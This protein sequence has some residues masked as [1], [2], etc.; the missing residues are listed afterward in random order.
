MKNNFFELPIPTREGEFIARYSKKG[1]AEMDFP[2]TRPTRRVDRTSL[3]EVSAASADLVSR[4]HRTTEAALK[5]ILAGRAAKT[6]PPLDTAGTEFQQA[7]WRELRKISFGKTKSYGEIAQAIGKPKAV[8]AVGAA[9]G[10]NPVPIVVPCH[11]VIGSSGKLTG[12]GG[13]L[14]LKKR[15]LQMEGVLLA[16]I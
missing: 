16:V 10:A 3:R 8:R 7:V 11:R 13:G 5:N 9:N 4:W 15:L 14:P 6:L 12:Y 1:L 2:A